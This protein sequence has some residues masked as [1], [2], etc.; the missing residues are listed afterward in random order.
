MKGAAAS[1]KVPSK[2]SFEVC[3]ACEEADSDP[4]AQLGI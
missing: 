2:L 3:L 1:G 4:R